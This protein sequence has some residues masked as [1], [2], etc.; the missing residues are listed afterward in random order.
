[1][2][3]AQ[4]LFLH[5][6]KTAGTTIRGIA[7]AHYGEARVAPIYPGERVY[8]GIEEFAN[9]P[10][11]QRDRADFVI[12]HFAYGFHRYLIGRRT[13]RYATVLREPISR[14]ASLYDHFA[15]RNAL[16]AAPSLSSVL[17]G[18]LGIQFNNYQT[19]MVSGMQAPLGPCPRA[20]L[21]KAKENMLQS[22]SF[23]GITELFDES[24]LLAE[25]LL[26]WPLKCYESRNVSENNPG[27]KL[28]RIAEGANKLDLARLEEMNALD[29]ELYDFSRD[30]LRS[31]LDATVPSWEIR[32]SAFHQRVEAMSPESTKS[33]GSLAPLRAG[34]IT[35]WSKLV[36]RDSTTRVRIEITG[37]ESQLVEASQKRDDLRAA[38]V[39]FTGA[40]GFV[41]DLP[42]GDGL[43]DGDTVR[44]FNAHTGVELTDSPRVFNRDM[45][46]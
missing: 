34:R 6:P 4:L 46:S 40:C 31:Q 18:S 3:D 35:G 38:D 29:R 26:G 36:G 45:D 1:M 43:H 10:A 21:D 13:F 12:G 32:L 25:A 28:H 8:L 27:W 2:S 30:R 24:L 39:H 5:V 11:E 37:R 16:G 14:C 23:V 15:A 41:L 44:A 42:N 17:S 19:R 33:V 20:M 7:Y 22:F 9:L